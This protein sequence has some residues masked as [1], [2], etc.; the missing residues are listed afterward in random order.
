MLVGQNLQ[1]TRH[2]RGKEPAAIR[3]C[4]TIVQEDYC[5]SVFQSPYR[6]PSRLRSFLHS[7]K[8]VTVFSSKTGKTLLIVVDLRFDP[9]SRLSVRNAHNYDRVHLV[10]WEVHALRGSSALNSQ[11]N[12]AICVAAGF[13]FSHQ[14]FV[15]FG[16]HSFSFAEQWFA[17][18]FF[19]APRDQ[20]VQHSE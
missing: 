2:P 16:G 14:S 8:D 12:G 4:E 10:P 5:A 9:W 18:R 13:E 11:K 17:Q 3:R 1:A 15:S 6:S 19:Q 7:G 20:R